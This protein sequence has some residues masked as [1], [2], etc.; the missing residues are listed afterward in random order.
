MLILLLVRT[1][2]KFSVYNGGKFGILHQNTEHPNKEKET[3]TW[4]KIRF[5][6]V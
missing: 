4:N 3:K 2:G 5:Y 1:N 6:I